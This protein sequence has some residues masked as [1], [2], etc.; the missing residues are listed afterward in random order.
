MPSPAM[1]NTQGLQGDKLANQIKNEAG[2]YL[3]ISGSTD[4]LLAIPAKDKNGLGP[5]FCQ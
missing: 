2:H 3:E 1:V 5:K 4:H